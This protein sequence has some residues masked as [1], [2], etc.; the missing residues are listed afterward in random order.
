[1]QKDQTCQSI[2]SW[3]EN[4]DTGVGKRWTKRRTEPQ[5]DLRF[6]VLYVD[7]VRVA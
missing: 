2:V 7:N 4:R 6:N 1:M 3:F 5:D